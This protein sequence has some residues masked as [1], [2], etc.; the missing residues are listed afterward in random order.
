MLFNGVYVIIGKSCMFNICYLDLIKLSVPFNNVSD[1]YVH[2]IDYVSNWTL[3]V[4]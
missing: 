2:Y 1:K 3:K 4:W